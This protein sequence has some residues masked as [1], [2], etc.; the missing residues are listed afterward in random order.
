[1]PIGDA[2]LKTEG[3]L[4]KKKTP[5]A[6]SSKGLPDVKGWHALS[7]RIL[8]SQSSLNTPIGG[9]DIPLACAGGKRK[10]LLQQLR[11]K[12]GINQGDGSLTC[13]RGKEGVC[14]CDGKLRKWTLSLTKKRSQPEDG[15][16]GGK[17][18]VSGGRQEKKK[19]NWGAVDEGRGG[20]SYP[21]VRLNNLLVVTRR[22]TS[23]ISTN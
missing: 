4:A 3:N 12:E 20:G 17:R 23:T 10:H 21:N 2:D 1:M 7:G 22:I 9:R 18:K 19:F 5:F 16:K 11:K 13:I 6:R 8:K 14:I 15:T